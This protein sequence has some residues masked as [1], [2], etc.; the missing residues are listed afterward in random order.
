MQYFGGKAR[1]SAE[2]AKFLQTYVSTDSIYIEP[3]VG[4]AWTF[5]RIKAKQ[6]IGGDINPSLIYMWR[7]LQ[8]GWIPPSTLSEED[9]YRIK[10]KGDFRNPLYAFAA[11]GCS[12]AGKFWGGYARGCTNYANGAK[13]SLLKKL[14]G[15]Q[16]DK[17]AFVLLDYQDW[18]SRTNSVFYCDPPYLGTTSYLGCPKFDHSVFWQKCRRWELEGNYVFVSEYQAPEDFECVWERTTK[19][20]IR[21]KENKPIVKVEKLFRLRQGE[22]G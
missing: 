3:F 14:R 13:N 10:E 15:L 22:L 9:Y 19:T 11:F 18:R 8:R 20:I 6:K 21:N 17:T 1:I 7:A 2:L 4:S 12:F 5:H 16:S